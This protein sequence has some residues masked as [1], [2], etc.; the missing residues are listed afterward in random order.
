MGEKAIK[1][2]MQHANKLGAGAKARKGLDQS[3]NAKAI[4]KE[5]G[6]GTLHSGGG[7]I[8]H[9]KKQAIA[10]IASTNKGRKK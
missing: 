10:I 1:K 4:M 7:G 9:S 6:R 8:V 5:F 2:A 3:D